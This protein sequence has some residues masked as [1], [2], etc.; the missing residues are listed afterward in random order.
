MDASQAGVSLGY[1]ERLQN[2][3]G[4]IV[5]EIDGK[6]A[7]ELYRRYLGGYA[8]ELPKSALNFPISIKERRDDSRNLIRSVLGIDEEKKALIFAGDVPTNYYARLMKASV[9]GLIDGSN[10]GSRR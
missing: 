5:Y 7:L 6:P 10:G 2:P 1:L 9:D 3:K 8:K 4:N